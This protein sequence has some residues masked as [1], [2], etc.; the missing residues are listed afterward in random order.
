MAAKRPISKSLTPEEAVYEQ[1]SAALDRFQEA[2]FWLHMVEQYYHAADPFRWHLNA[3]LRAMKEVP[4]LLQMELQGHPGFKTW[5]ATKRRALSDDPLQR[6]LSQHRDFVVHRGMLVP[7]SSAM[8]GV[9]EGRG[10]KF[11][12][13]FPVHALED[14]DHGMRRYL[15]GSKAHGDFL[16]IMTPDEDFCP[17]SNVSGISPTSTTRSVR[18]AHGRGCASARLSGRF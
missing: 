6:V 8:V 5:F 10:M 15:A 1:I 14:S 18:S 11:G 3:F 4:Q 7:R 17:V 13:K 2:H 16:G 9:T 12:M